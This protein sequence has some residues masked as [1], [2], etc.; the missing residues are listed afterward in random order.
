M[1]TGRFCRIPG[2]WIPGSRHEE[3]YELRIRVSGQHGPAFE[4][5]DGI[6][7]SAKDLVGVRGG[8]VAVGKYTDLRII[9]KE[10]CQAIGVVVDLERVL[11]VWPRRVRRLGDGNAQVLTARQLAGTGHDPSVGITIEPCNPNRS[12]LGRGHSQAG[13][14]RTS[15]CRR[16]P[17]GHCRTCRKRPSQY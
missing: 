8:V 3:G 1:A 7:Q 5:G 15:L 11:I 17:P 2:R 14:A 13:P 10:V 9:V 16:D 12:R 4:R 6:A